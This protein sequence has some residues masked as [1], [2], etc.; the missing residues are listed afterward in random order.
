MNIIG[1]ARSDGDGRRN[2]RVRIVILEQKILGLIVGKALSAVLDHQARERPRLARQ[3]K[4]VQTNT[5]GSS[6]HSRASMWVRSA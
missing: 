5:P 1:E 2:V 6:P 3:L 4:P